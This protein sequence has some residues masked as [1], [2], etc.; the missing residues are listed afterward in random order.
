[1]TEIMGDK[2]GNGP[3]GAVNRRAFL[4]AAG[5]G[6]VAL[7]IPLPFLGKG[8]RAGAAAGDFEPNAWLRVGADGRFIF[9]LDRAEM[10]QGVMTALPTLLGEELDVDPSRFVIEHAPVDHRYD[11]PTLNMQVT[12]GSTSVFAAWGPLRKAGA[13]ARARFVGAAAQ[14]WNVPVGELTTEDGMVMHAASGKSAPY[15]TFV[16]KAA[17]I[18]VDDEKVVLKDPAKFRWIGKSRDRLE[19]DLK[20]TGRASFGIDTQPT[21]MRVA[22]AVMAPKL[23]S[24]VKSVDDAAA[25]AMDGVFGIHR[26]SFGVAVVARSYWHAKRA[27]EALVIT[28]DDDSVL[29]KISTAQIRADY[30]ALA[31]SGDG[32]K[33]ARDDG[34]VDAVMPTAKAKVE[35]VYEAPYWAHATMEP[36]NCTAVVRDGHCE[37]WVPT[38]APTL[39][40]RA[41]AVAS[42]LPESDVTVHTTL[43]GGGFGR[44][45]MTDFVVQAVEIAKAHGTTP[46]K[47]VWSREQDMQQ[48]PYRPCSYHALTAGIDAEGNPIAWTHRIVAQ[49]ILGQLVPSWAPAMMPGWIPEFA[50]TWAGS[51]AG[52]AMGKSVDDT[53]VEGAKD[54]PYAIPNVYVDYI[55]KDH[56]VPV[57]FWRSVGHSYTGFVVESFMDEVA[58]LAGKDPYEYRRGLLKGAPR[59]LAVLE[60]VAKKAGWSNA[61]MGE[62]KGRGIAQ[63]ASFRS[64]AAT[65]AEVE[66]KGTEIRVTRVVTVIDCGRVINPDML[67]AQ[68]ESATIY[69]LTALLKSDITHVDGAVVQSNFHDYTMLR[70]N[71]APVIE[72]EVIPSDVD[73]TGVGEPG[74][75]PVLGAV[76]NAVFAATKQ[77]LRSMPLKLS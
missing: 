66:V 77:R 47:L 58:H 42:G 32:A 53:A 74:L 52:W 45:S 7:M 27:A 18:E 25:K 71:E 60:A 13:S 40:R 5:A 62:G 21:D 70:L 41:A 15:G 2:R 67:K 59:N 75:P 48:S 57:A 49:S 44:R 16:E 72:V 76:A 6:V 10:G 9:V 65:V 8:G 12:G 50:K 29:S 68:V 69:G 61:P 3:S 33:D 14:T 64:F 23:G 38:Q 37:V 20:V 11:N 63:H 26:V 73:P 34:D 55:H 19:N 28:W 35:A 46:V 51:A 31:K 54:H 39:A 56:G 24:T 22:F 36:Q 30:A 43:L 17:T 4:Q 1:M